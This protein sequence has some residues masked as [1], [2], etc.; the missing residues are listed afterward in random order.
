MSGSPSSPQRTN[1]NKREW[2][3]LTNCDSN[4]LQCL[5][6][7]DL[8]IVKNL[9]IWQVINQSLQG[10][11][12]LDIIIQVYQT[13]SKYKN[14]FLVLN[15]N[16]QANKHLKCYPTSFCIVARVFVGQGEFRVCITR[17][18]WKTDTSNILLASAQWDLSLW[19]GEHKDFDR[20]NNGFFRGVSV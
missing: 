20:H 17:V 14:R 2:F 8:I 19:L 3:Y 10:V 4:R 16:S 5:P 6:H 12:F 15:E 7:I 11:I 1:L 9:Q 13:T 18:I